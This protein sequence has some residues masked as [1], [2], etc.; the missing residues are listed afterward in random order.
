MT[1]KPEETKPEQENKNTQEPQK[2]PNSTYNTVPIAIAIVA[3]GALIGGAIFLSANFN[4]SNNQG[5]QL[6]T[7]TQTAEQAAAQQAELAKKSA[8]V[9][10][11]DHIRGSADAKIFLVEYSDLDCPYCSQAHETLKQIVVQYNGEVAW[12]YRHFPL[13]SL[14]PYAETKAQ[15]SECVAELGGNNAF[16]N[17]VDAYF[18][19][20]D[21]R[22]GV[23]AAVSVA[24]AQGINVNQLN[25]CIT[26]DKHKN[27]VQEQFDNAVESGGRGTPYVVITDGEN[28]VPVEGA[29]AASVFTSHIDEMLG[30]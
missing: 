29:R 8:E 17:F 18:P 25:T 15:A 13:T 22:A 27:K 5:N 16:W 11:T 19:V 2:S 10:E 6:G 28:F 12:V 7:T 14:H 30:N 9:T 1:T 21:P 26:S 24:S 23:E 4:K 20:Q 3:A